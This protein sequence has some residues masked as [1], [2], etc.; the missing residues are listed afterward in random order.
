M[1]EEKDRITGWSWGRGKLELVLRLFSYIAYSSS[2]NVYF[3]FLVF[4][5]PWSSRFLKYLFGLRDRILRSGGYVTLLVCR[6]GAEVWDGEYRLVRSE[7]MVSWKG[8]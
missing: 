5:N 1:E 8:R 4:H 6:Q 2:Q 3:F 7:L